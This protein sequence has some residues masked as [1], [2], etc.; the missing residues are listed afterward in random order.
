MYNKYNCKINFDFQSWILTT[1]YCAS[2]ND[3]LDHANFLVVAGDFDVGVNGEDS[4]QVSL[5]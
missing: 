1:G 4:E 5:P 3:D 2:L